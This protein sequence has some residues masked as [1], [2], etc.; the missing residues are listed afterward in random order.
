[1]STIAVAPRATTLADLVALHA[2][3]HARAVVSRDAGAVVD[4]LAASLRSHGERV[5]TLVPA[6]ATD[7]EVLSVEAEGARTVTHTRFVADRGDTVVRA[8]WAEVDGRP[9]IVEARVA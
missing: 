5:G 2:E 6:R 1:M 9:R 4:D 7:A 8:V 3:A